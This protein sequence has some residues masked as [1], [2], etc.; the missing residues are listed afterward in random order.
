MCALQITTYKYLFRMSTTYI[1]VSYYSD[2]F[3]LTKRHF[4]KYE[5]IIYTDKK[6]LG[7]AARS[8]Y[9]IHWP[10]SWNITYGKLGYGILHTAYLYDITYDESSWNITYRTYQDMKYQNPSVPKALS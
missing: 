3:C 1:E 9:Y 4:G 8:Y 5:K 2:N 6:S 7:I 10:F